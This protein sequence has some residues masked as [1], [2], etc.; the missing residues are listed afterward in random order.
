MVGRMQLVISVSARLLFLASLTAAAASNASSVIPVTEGEAPAWQVEC[1]EGVCRASQSLKNQESG[2]LLATLTFVLEPDGAAGGFILDVP[3]GVAL[4]PGV[5]LLFDD[6]EREL[7]A[8]V[9]YPDGCRFTKRLVVPEFSSLIESNT[10]EV[11][12]F[13]YGKTDAPIAFKFGVEGLAEAFAP[14]LK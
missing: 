3:L 12:Y 9:C 5:R 6:N 8:D 13:A 11:R 7:L 14:H 1:V 10:I 2:Q 4:R